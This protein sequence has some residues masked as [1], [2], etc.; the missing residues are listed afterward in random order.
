MQSDL[1]DL[2]PVAYTHTECYSISKHT[3]ISAHSYELTRNNYIH[4]VT[5]TY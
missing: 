5:H 4:T 1:L 2:R 3:F